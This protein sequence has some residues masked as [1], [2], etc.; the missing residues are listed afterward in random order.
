MNSRNFGNF[1]GPLMQPRRMAYGGYLDSIVP[2]VGGGSFTPLTAPTQGGSLYQHPG[3]SSSVSG[4]PMPFSSG[5]DYYARTQVPVDGNPATAAYRPGQLYFQYGA[6]AAAATGGDAVPRQPALGLP[7]DGATQGGLP[8]AAPG[9]EGALT[10]FEGSQG[11]GGADPSN[12]GT[13]GGSGGKETPGATS[14]ADVGGFDISGKDIGGALG[15]LLGGLAGPLGGLA[16]KAVGALMGSAFDSAPGSMTAGSQEA[17]DISSAASA[18]NAAANAAAD[19][20]GG[21]GGSGGYGNGNAGSDPTGGEGPAG[22]RRGGKVQGFADGGLAVLAN[23]V[24]DASTVPGSGLA[25]LSPDMQRTVAQLSAPQMNPATGVP[26]YARGGLSATQHNGPGYVGDKELGGTG[27]S[28]GVP[29]MLSNNEYVID[30]E[31][32]ALLGDGDP[33]AG[34]KKLDQ[35]RSNIRK[36]KGAAL[37]KGKI[38]ADAKSPEHYMGGLSAKKGGA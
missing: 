12:G 38:S 9:Y 17:S 4:I 2:N 27:R 24:R 14:P 30:A 13:G 36:Q 33:K 32:N 35:M 11:R 6:P 28:D 29:A 20:A 15:G 16:G 25:Y 10:A 21:Y 19:Q 34:A 26:Q 23:Q 3:Q 8:G 22:L 31:T 5:A 1:T 18:D 37:A 7:I